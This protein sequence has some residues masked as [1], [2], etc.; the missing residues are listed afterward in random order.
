MTHLCL[1]RGTRKHGQFRICQEKHP[2]IVIYCSSLAYRNLWARPQSTDKS[3]HCCSF[4]GNQ[5]TRQLPPNLC[6]VH[7]TVLE[8]HRGETWRDRTVTKERSKANSVSFHFSPTSLPFFYPLC[9]ITPK[10]LFLSD[11][12][13]GGRCPWCLPRWNCNVFQVSLRVRLVEMRPESP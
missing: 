4:Q 11:W 7:H 12:A 9:S 3:V 1:L 6:T 10:L 13:L 5:E 2:K 8:R